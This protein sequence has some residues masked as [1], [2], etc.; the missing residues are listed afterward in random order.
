MKSTNLKIIVSNPSVAPHVRQTVKAYHDAGFLYRLFTSFFDH[1]QNKFS[2]LLRKI[3]PLEKEIS[4]RAYHELPI[5]KFRSRP[6]PELLRSVAARFVSSTVTD[7]IWEWSELGFD[8]WVAG[9]LDAT[10][11][12]VHTY[13]HAA[14]ATLQEAKD[15]DIF[16]IYEQPSQHHSF[17]TGIA[18][19]QI[20]LYPELNSA[21]AELLINDKAQKRNQRRDQELALASL[22]ICNST[23]TK[24]TLVAGGVDPEKI[25]VIPL[26]FPE[27]NH[28]SKPQ[29]DKMPLVFFYAVNQS[30]IKATH[31]LYLAW[32]KCNFSP[33]EAELWL[34]GKMLLPESLRSDLPGK[35]IIKE[36]IPHEE[37]MANYEKADVFVLPTLADGFGMVITEAMSQG[38]PVIASENSCG[39]DV[40]EHDKNGWLI[41]AGDVNALAAQMKRCVENRENVTS[42]GE[43]A[44]VKAAEW[45]WPQY[46]QK[47]TETVFNEWQK[48]KQAK[49]SV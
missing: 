42:C 41:P 47:L 3:K 49:Q 24:K 21:S 18:K 6:L 14:L 35:V 34:I 26:A 37:L 33:D 48:F 31:L 15:L 8:K 10:I 23:F 29:K 20:A 13:E 12:S 11:D 40:I 19:Q 5:E 44:K 1:P 30:L 9:N 43:V 28:R 22:I 7:S 45:Q 25:T 27:V 32:R 17:F 2:S 39:P 36:N 4:R 38:V 46:R 16:G